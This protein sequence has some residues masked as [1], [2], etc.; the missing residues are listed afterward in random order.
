[1]VNNFKRT[2]KEFGL[3]DGQI[4]RVIKALEYD[5]KGLDSRAI[6]LIDNAVKNYGNTP[7]ADVTATEAVRGLLKTLGQGWP[8][9]LAINDFCAL[10][11]RVGKRKK[12]DGTEGIGNALF[13]ITEYSIYNPKGANRLTMLLDAARYKGLLKNKNDNTFAK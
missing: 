13:N 4:K 9:E 7:T 1:M 8:Q 6:A 11:Y 3:T 12:K 5:Q 2:L 10:I